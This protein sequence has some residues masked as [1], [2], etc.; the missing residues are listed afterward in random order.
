MIEASGLLSKYLLIIELRFGA[1]FY[2]RLDNENSDAGHVKCSRRPHVS[3]PCFR[4]IKELW[5]EYFVTKLIKYEGIWSN[6]SQHR[7]RNRQMFR[8]SKNFYPNFSKLARYVFVRLL[9]T[10]F[11]PQRS[12]R[13]YFGVT[14]IKR[15]S[16]VFLQML[17]TIFEIK[18]CWAPFL[19]GYFGFCPDCAWIFVRIFDKSKLWRVRLQSCLLHHWFTV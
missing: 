1:I 18:Q 12:W 17:D 8:G 9:T 19:P 4:W 16:C 10:N 2:S 14:S 3:Q 13:P 7:C 15:S 11:L 5:P 6:K